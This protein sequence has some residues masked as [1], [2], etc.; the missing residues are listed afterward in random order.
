V[1][2]NVEK[3]SPAEQGRAQA[4]RRDPRYNGK[5]IEDP[6]ELPRLVAATKPGEKA[7]LEVWRNGK[8]EQARGHR[9]R[10]PDRRRERPRARAG[11]GDA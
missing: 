3:G 8:R 5:K 6:N 11:E 7:T 2:T 1:I 10:V 9:G 4:W